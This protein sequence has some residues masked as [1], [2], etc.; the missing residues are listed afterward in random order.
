M[1]KWLKHA[2][3]IET[4]GTEEPSEEVRSIVDR[5]CREVIRRH[6]TT[7][8]LMALEMSRPLNFIGAQTLHFFTPMLSAI[9]DAT[10]YVRFAE[11][12]EQRGSIDYL[13]ERLEAAEHDARI[14]QQSLQQA[15]NPQD[16]AST[17]SLASEPAK[18]MDTQDAT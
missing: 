6:L 14:A 8:A 11:F 1:F 17:G 13:C 7:P 15:T 3:A 4:S 9:T 5:L 10:G 2:F 18:D 16:D 12:L